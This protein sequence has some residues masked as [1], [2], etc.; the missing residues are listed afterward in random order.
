MEPLP[1]DWGRGAVV[2]AH[3]DDVEYG[4]ASAVARFTSHDKEI[5]YVL[6]T[7]GEAGIDGMAPEE[8]GTVREDEQ[9][10]SA[11]VV[12]VGHVEYLGHQTEPSSTASA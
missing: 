8:C 2:V 4:M 12:G 7:K 5:S 3:P 1:E 10:R 11:A 9:H 6:A